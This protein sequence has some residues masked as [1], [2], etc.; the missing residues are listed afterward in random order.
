MRICLPVLLFYSSSC[1]YKDLTKECASGF[2]FVYLQDIKGQ[3]W[4]D[5]DSEGDNES[6]EFLYGVQVRLHSPKLSV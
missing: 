4:N 1:S 3:F 6:E 2:V 5:D